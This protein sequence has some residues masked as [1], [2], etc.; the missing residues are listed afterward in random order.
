MCRFTCNEEVGC[1][2]VPSNKSI[3]AAVG[4]TMEAAI[5]D[6]NNNVDMGLASL[7]CS[8]E[9]VRKRSDGDSIKTHKELSCGHNP[10]AQ[11]S[12]SAGDSSL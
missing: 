8:S 7:Q 10:F 1:V 6:Q 11:F 12:L 4:N 5:T 2:P 9:D 3:E